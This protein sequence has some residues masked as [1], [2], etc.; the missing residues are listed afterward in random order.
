VTLTTPDSS[1]CKVARDDRLQR[2]DRVRGE[3]HRVLAGVRHCRVRTFSRDDDLEDVERAHQRTDAGRDLAEGEQ[4]PVVHAE[5][6]AHREALEETLLDHHPA[7]ALVLL[8]R[9]E[10]EVLPCR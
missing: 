2:A 5:D 10:D 7:A 6:R 1:G 8:G 4:R 3:Q 9:L